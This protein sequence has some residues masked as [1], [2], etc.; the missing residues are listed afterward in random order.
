MVHVLSLGLMLLFGGG[1]DDVD[2]DPWSPPPTLCEELAADP[3]L[4]EATLEKC[5][6]IIPFF[7]TRGDKIHAVGVVNGESWGDCLAND[8]AWGRLSGGRPEG[9]WSMMSHLGWP[10]RLLGNHLGGMIDVRNIGHASYIA[11]LLVYERPSSHLGFHHWWSIHRGP[12]NPF[13]VRWGVRPIWYC[14]PDASYW[15]DVPA[16]SNFVCGGVDYGG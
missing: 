16:G 1:F 14:P 9:C 12:L 6:Q 4:T 11:S 8:R 5:E 3:W 2:N 15:D 13:L 10:R 7:K